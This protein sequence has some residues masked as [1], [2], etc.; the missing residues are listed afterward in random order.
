MANNITILDVMEMARR[1]D[2][3][4]LIRA[5]KYQADISVRAEAVMA[6]GNTGDRQAVEPLVEV[7]SYDSDPY[8]RSLA[9]KALGELGDPR[10]QT[11]LSQALA[12]D[13]S[14]EVGLEASRALA[15]LSSRPLEADQVSASSIPAVKTE[16]ESSQPDESTFSS[17]GRESQIMSPSEPS[18][19][20]VERPGC[21][22]FFAI[23]TA[24][25]SVLVIGFGG[26]Y[27][28]SL[29]I[30]GNVGEGLLA[31]LVSIGVG[32]LYLIF[33]R[34]LWNMR[35][36]AR[37]IILVFS[38]IGLVGSVI[39]MCT[40]LSGDAVGARFLAGLVGLIIPGIFFYWFYDNGNLFS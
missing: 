27:G 36:W 20:A 17:S 32:S 15:K 22:A 35:N 3:Q 12:S 37:V 33:A 28:L 31:L 24:I 34:G 39:T 6:L 16:L 4:G 40:S 25:I 21:V 26:L 38:G 13:I 1:K 19:S 29:I 8:V 7:L 18:I 10:A 9:A 11:A 2:V 14:S 23:P 5:L 30:E